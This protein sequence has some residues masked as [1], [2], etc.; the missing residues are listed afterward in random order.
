MKIIIL[1]IST[2]SDLY[3]SFNNTIRS[4]WGS[5]HNPNIRIIYCYGK[6]FLDNNGTVLINDRLYC[7]QLESYE[8]IGRKTI[9]SFEYILQ[10]F[11]FDYIFRTNESSYIIQEKLFT[12]LE[13]KTNIKNY[14]CGSILYHEP[15]PFLA[16]SGY[17]L[18][19]DITQLIVI[20]KNEWE[21]QYIDDVALGLFLIKYN[22][23]IVEGDFKQDFTNQQSVEINDNKWHF[24][25]K[26]ELNRYIDIE[27]MKKIHNIT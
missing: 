16:G 19:K 25:C 20:N 3:K 18:S 27:N 7:N 13:N 11:E 4:T 10:N 21:H 23:N 2:H 1:V 8:N 26:N 5:I 9:D 17:I 22:I 14:A 15:F 6:P 12:F 24:R